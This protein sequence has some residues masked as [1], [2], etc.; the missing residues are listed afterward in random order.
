MKNTSIPGSIWKQAACLGASLLLLGPA[1]RLFARGA[2]PVAQPVFIAD[3]DLSIVLEA[4]PSPRQEVIIERDRPSRDH[5]WVRGYWINRH[6]HHEWVAG[7]WEVPPR[8]RTVW[9]E[10]RWERRG[11]GYI[12]IEGYWTVGRP[13][14]RR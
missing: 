13:D 10:P 11:R 4:P 14:D 3:V 8:G 1:T 9:I 5:V 2:P 6:G 7:H 12:F